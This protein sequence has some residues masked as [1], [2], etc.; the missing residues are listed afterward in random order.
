MLRTIAAQ[1]AFPRRYRE[2]SLA[3][4]ELLR[5]ERPLPYGLG[6]VR[7]LSNSRPGLLVIWNY[8]LV[9]D[10]RD[11]VAL[12]AGG[13]CEQNEG[14]LSLCRRSR[15]ND[16]LRRSVI[17]VDLDQVASFDAQLRHVLGIHLDKGIGPAILHKVVLLVEVGALPNMVRAAI[18]D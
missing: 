2:W 3:D 15:I 17:V 10:G 14:L 1:S 12:N 18:I 13:I 8:E 6:C 9:H 4:G 7:Y 11:D 16:S 5:F